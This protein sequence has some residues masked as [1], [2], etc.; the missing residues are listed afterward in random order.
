MANQIQLRPV[1]APIPIP[2][3]DDLIAVVPPIRLPSKRYAYGVR[4]GGAPPG[5]AFTQDLQ[6]TGTAAVKVEAGTIPMQ[7]SD[8]FVVYMQAEC[9]TISI[10]PEPRKWIERLKMMFRVYERAA[11]ERVF[12]TGDGMSIGPSLGN[13][14]MENLSVDAVD[15]LRALQLLETAVARH[16]SGIIH[17]APSTVI[18]WDAL[19]LTV[20]QDGLTYTKRGTPIAVGAGYIDAVPDGADPLN[21]EEQW[22]FASG[23]LEIQSGMIDIPAQTYQEILDRTF[24]DVVVVAER[25]YVFNW[26]ARQDPTDP[27]QTQA[28]VLVHENLCACHVDGGGP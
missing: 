20:A 18:A 9:T 2:R 16:S 13:A 23:P 3:T 4:S 17:A 8:L 10:G 22:A 21:D 5:P 11:V 12:V 7:D 19:N 26:M 15:P 1:V 28:G 25:P 6:S 27:D 14:N 24:N